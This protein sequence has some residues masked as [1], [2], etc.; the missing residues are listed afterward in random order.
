MAGA[1]PGRPD[2]RRSVGALGEATAAAWY[3]NG[4]YEVLDRNWRCRDGEIDLVRRA[5]PGRSSSA[6]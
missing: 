3:E 6:R 5:R 2:P 1:R 4:G